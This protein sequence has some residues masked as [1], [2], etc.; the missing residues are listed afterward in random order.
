MRYYNFV[1]WLLSRLVTSKKPKKNC[2]VY[3][4]VIA[5]DVEGNSAISLTSKL[6][7]GIVT[8]IPDNF[9]L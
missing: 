6:E 1:K 4:R 9:N 2:P 3:F 8:P 7:N 5:K